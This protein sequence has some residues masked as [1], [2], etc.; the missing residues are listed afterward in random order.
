MKVKFIRSI[1]DTIAIDDP[2]LAI[3]D[4]DDFTG[5]FGADQAESVIAWIKNQNREP[6]APHVIAPAIVVIGDAL[7]A[8]NLNKL[9]RAGAIFCKKPE[10]YDW[11]SEAAKKTQLAQ[12]FA[13]GLSPDPATDPPAGEDSS[14]GDISLYVDPPFQI[15][16]PDYD[17]LMQ[18]IRAKDDDWNKDD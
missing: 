14:N 7:A 9:A 6:A 17:R 3:L 4:M 11:L 5:G 18:R 10:G 1:D 8:E 12:L 16:D 15:S 13:S 2:A